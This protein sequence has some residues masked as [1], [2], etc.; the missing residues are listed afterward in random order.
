MGL[1][2]VVN[3]WNSVTSKW[4]QRWRA[5][6]GAAHVTIRDSLVDLRS[7][8]AGQNLTVNASSGS[9]D[10][11]DVLG[12]TS[13]MLYISGAS[14]ADGVRVAQG[15]APVTAATSP[16]LPVGQLL[17]PFACDATDKLAVRS[18]DANTGVCHIIPLV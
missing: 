5:T 14:I 8:V 11:S 6:D 17:G 2:V 3:L 13:F 18:N 16:I 1:S 15:S 10:P 4:D 7:G 12:V 9:D